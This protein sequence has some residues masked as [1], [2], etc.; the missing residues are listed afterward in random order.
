MMSTREPRSPSLP[1]SFAQALEPEIF[2]TM[3][4]WYELFAEALTSE[5]GQAV[6][7]HKFRQVLAVDGRN[8]E[9]LSA[10]VML[11][12]RG[13]RSAFLAMRDHAAW[14]LEHEPHLSA[15]VRAFLIQAL[16]LP[17]PEHPPSRDGV[18]DSLTRDIGVRVLVEVAAK[19]WSLPKLNS[20]DRQRSAA[21][22]VGLIFAEHGHRVRSERHIRRIY[23]QRNR[24]A[25]R[26]TQAL[27]G[28]RGEQTTFKV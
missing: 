28:D 5:A 1:A 21:H 17:M 8:P 16:Y 18:I 20:T 22:Y 23:Q 19:R 25:E 24:L 14:V 12:A 15:S 26:L 3:R 4:H 6:L 9:V 13:H 27:I 7:E 11:A 2:A 10:L